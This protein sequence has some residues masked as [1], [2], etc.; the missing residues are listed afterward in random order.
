MQNRHITSAPKI[1]PAN[2]DDAIRSTAKAVVDEVLARLGPVAPLPKKWLTETQ[3]EQYVGWARGTLG[4]KRYRGD[5][6]P[7]SYGEGKMRRTKVADVDAF[8][9]SQKVSSVSS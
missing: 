6:V 3:V 2:P 9:E 5:S 7:K 1:L 4:V 8:I